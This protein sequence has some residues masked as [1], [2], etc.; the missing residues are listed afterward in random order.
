MPLLDDHEGN[1]RLITGRNDR[2]RLPQLVHLVAQHRLELALR[3]AVAEE[4][5][6]LRVALVAR[7]VLGEQARAH[8]VQVVDHLVG[9][10]LGSL[11]GTQAGRFLKRGIFSRMLLGPC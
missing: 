8:L 7:L 9:L 2:A 5:D 3:D 11:L 1:T 10:L 4:H 6:A